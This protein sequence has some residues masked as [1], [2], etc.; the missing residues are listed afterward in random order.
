M[1]SLMLKMYWYE[2]SKAMV[3]FWE[4]LT[5]MPL[6]LPQLTLPVML[7]QHSKALTA[8]RS[9]WYPLL[10]IVKYMLPACIILDQS[11]WIS[12]GILDGEGL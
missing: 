3:A 4:G 1:Y 2:V 5:K 9:L 8:T 11:S 7:L 10:A 12:Q 6:L